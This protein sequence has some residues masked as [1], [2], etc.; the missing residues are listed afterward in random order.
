MRIPFAIALASL[1]SLVDILPLLGAGAILLPLAAVS[2]ITG[3][4]GRCLGFLTLLGILY[5]TRQIV[6]PHIV[7]KK[8]GLPPFFSFISTFTGLYLFGPSGA[9]IIPIT[10]AV[11]KQELIDKKEDR[12]T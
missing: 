4:F 5:V 10:V 6:E 2:A 1:V 9:I 8:I 12:V 3:Q 11:I 7:G